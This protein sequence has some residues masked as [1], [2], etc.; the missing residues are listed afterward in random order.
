[1]ARRSSVSESTETSSIRTRPCVLPA[2]Q[3][4]KNHEE[5][6][7]K[8][9]SGCLPLHRKMANPR[10]TRMI[11][12]GPYRAWNCHLC[13]LPSP[14]SEPWMDQESPWETAKARLLSAIGPCR[15]PI[16]SRS[17]GGISHPEAKMAAELLIFQEIVK[18]IGNPEH[19]NTGISN[20]G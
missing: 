11:P 3:C 13:G 2:G 5:D 7:R 12:T 15:K 19:R 10:S 9:D 14:E 6:H 16:E 20:I 4:Q 18:M 1:M 8:P 17:E